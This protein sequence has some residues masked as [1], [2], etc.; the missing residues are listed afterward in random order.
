M[1]GVA[2]NPPE[3]F[4]ASSVNVALVKSV[5]ISISLPSVPTNLAV[6]V[7]VSSSVSSTAVTKLEFATI[8]SANFVTALSAVKVTPTT[9]GI[10]VATAI[11][12]A[13]ATNS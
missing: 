3:R 1:Q 7:T 13:S 11:S 4:V 2:Y 10:F 12:S 5:A 6:I 8:A 9:T